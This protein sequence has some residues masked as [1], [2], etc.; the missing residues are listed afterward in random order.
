ML[1]CVVLSVLLPFLSES[2]QI[3][4]MSC[5]CVTDLPVPAESLLLLSGPRLE[6]ALG[7]YDRL[8]ASF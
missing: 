1:C 5:F 2:K 4:E 3:L 7:D 8:P 6:P